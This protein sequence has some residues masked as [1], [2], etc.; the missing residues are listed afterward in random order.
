MDVLNP[1]LEEIDGIMYRVNPVDH[2]VSS[3]NAEI[4]PYHEKGTY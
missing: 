4:T 1:P 3:F 2:L